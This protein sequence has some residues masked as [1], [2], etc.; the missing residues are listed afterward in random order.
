MDASIT[1]D[2][3]YFSHKNLRK[4][5]KWGVQFTV[6]ITHRERKKGVQM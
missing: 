5:L 4:I 6:I 2:G 3:M 1:E